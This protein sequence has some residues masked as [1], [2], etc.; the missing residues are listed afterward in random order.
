MVALIGMISLS[1]SAW[2]II[3]AP[4]ALMSSIF[5]LVY[6]RRLRDSLRKTAIKS[7]TKPENSGFLGQK[8]IEIN[9][10]GIV[11]IS[12]ASTALYKWNTVHEIVTTP[13]HAFLRLGSIQALVIPR[14]KIEEGDYEAFVA[15]AKHL[16]QLAT[17][18]KVAQRQPAA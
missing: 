2:W 17:G 10:E 16:H 3:F 12:E 18:D 9:G 14:T 6:P 7:A 4:V 13:D 5:T 1:F 15:E 11:S 8:T